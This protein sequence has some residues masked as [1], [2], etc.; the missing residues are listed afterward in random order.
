[1][2]ASRISATASALIEVRSST[3]GAIRRDPDSTSSTRTLR[4]SC[5]A[6]KLSNGS[7]EAAGVKAVTAPAATTARRLNSP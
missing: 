3:A 6:V 4:S 5:T 1:M 2:I 7:S